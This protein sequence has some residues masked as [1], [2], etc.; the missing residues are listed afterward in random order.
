[1]VCSMLTPAG[2][3]KHHTTIVEHEIF[4]LRECWRAHFTNNNNDEKI[5][6]LVSNFEL[7]VIEIL[8]YKL[9]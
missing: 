4:F 1:M 9:V 3:S 8:K 6:V 5:L 7:F 2:G